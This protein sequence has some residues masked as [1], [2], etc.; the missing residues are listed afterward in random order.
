MLKPIVVGLFSAA[1]S[2]FAG[3]AKFDYI[4]LPPISPEP[5]HKHQPGKIIWHDL[6]TDTPEESKV[7]YGELFGWRFETATLKSDSGTNLPY[8]LIFNHGRMIGG[9]VDEN[10]LRNPQ[11]ISQWI[12][13]MSVR[14]IYAAAATLR[15]NGGQLIGRITDLNE[16]GRIAV[17]RDNQ[18][19]LFT[20]LE[21]KS[22]DPADSDTIKTGDFL[23]DELWSDDI[24]SSQ[25]F[26][27]Q[28][29]GYSSEQVEGANNSAYA[30]LSAQNKSRVGILANPVEG[31]SPV[32]VNYLRIDNE[33]HMREILSKVT[34]LGGE[35]LLDAQPRAIGGLVAII[36]GPSGAVIA[37]QTWEKN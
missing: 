35:V 12:T 22:G 7:F 33:E 10:D 14:D 36:K 28:L 9:L 18:N 20:L 17:V 3:C 29:I 31:L 27:E 30:I 32:W 21:T 1:L 19:A 2:L 5:T 23:W 24:R 8:T 26:Y 15:D 37:L 4:N 13:V 34:G 16:R 11:E 25:L 6:I